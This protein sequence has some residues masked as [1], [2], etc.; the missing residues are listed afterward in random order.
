MTKNV[1]SWE[2]L[3]TAVIVLNVTGLLDPTLKCIDKF[4]LRQKSI[5]SD[6]YMFKVSKNRTMF[7][8]Y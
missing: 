5:P 8:I 3:L 1:S 2:L 4:R 6:T 7:Q